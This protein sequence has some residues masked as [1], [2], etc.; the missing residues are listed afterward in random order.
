MESYR[1][2][3]YMNSLFSGAKGEKYL[4][5][6]MKS[7]HPGLRY[8]SKIIP[9]LR[10]FSKIYLQEVLENCQRLMTRRKTNE[11]TEQI[12]ELANWEASRK[13]WRS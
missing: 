8:D 7:I 1:E 10:D 3:Y 13:I 6:I 2:Y 9:I 12:F 11:I 4:Q 5:S